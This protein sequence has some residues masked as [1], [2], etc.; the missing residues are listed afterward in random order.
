MNICCYT[1]KLIMNKGNERVFIFQLGSQIYILAIVNHG[2][3]YDEWS[4][5]EYQNNLYIACTFQYYDTCWPSSFRFHSPFS[6][7]N[8]FIPLTSFRYPPP[9]FLT[10]LPILN[11]VFS[12][13]PSPNRIFSW[14]VY[15]Y[16]NISLQSHNTEKSLYEL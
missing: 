9:H 8:S 6:N 1:R 13:S 10:D 4:C 7:Y 14:L 12:Y 15:Q 11:K 5:H 2:P 3:R 16:G